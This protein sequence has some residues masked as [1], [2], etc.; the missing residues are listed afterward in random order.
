MKFVN[1]LV[2]RKGS[3]LHKL[4]EKH[5]YTNFFEYPIPSGKDGFLATNSLLAFVII[6]YR[7]YS[8]ASEKKSNLPETL[9]KLR[10]KIIA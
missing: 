2:G 5:E 3:K 7:A 4:S 9:E 10:K 8:E 6:L 1:A